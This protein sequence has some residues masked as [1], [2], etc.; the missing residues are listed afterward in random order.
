MAATVTSLSFALFAACSSSGGKTAAPTTI[1]SVTPTTPAPP[2]TQSVQQ[3]ASIVA[4]YRA[5]IRADIAGL[6]ACQT[7]GSDALNDA[8]DNNNH[9]GHVSI[10]ILTESFTCQDV[11]IKSATPTIALAQDLAAARPPAEIATLTEE[12]RAAAKQ[13]STDAHDYFTCVMNAHTD[14]ALVNCT[15]LPTFA[16]SS[17]TIL[18]KLNG[19]DAYLPSAP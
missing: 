5:Q 11:L 10:E 1:A 6:P 3:V 17:E 7:M 16:G 13:A 2:A 12:T 18:E 15:L 9:T 14:D 8:V 4:Q 19:W